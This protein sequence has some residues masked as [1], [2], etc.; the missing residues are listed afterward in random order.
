MKRLALL[1][2]AVVAFGPLTGHAQTSS[3]TTTATTTQGSANCGVLTQAA[4]NALNGRLEA[5]NSY[6]K[7]PE[8]VGTLSCLDSIFS[9][10]GLN[11]ISNITNPGAM[12]DSLL[13]NVEGQ[14]CSAAQSAWNGTVGA[15]QQCG[16]G[17]NGVNLGLGLDTGGGLMCPSLNFGGDGPQL[18]SVGVGNSTSN[19]YNNGVPQ[20]P[21]GYSD[22]TPSGGIF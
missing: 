18:G 11:L 14:I 20:L 3:A 22:T 2:G 16:L 12:I 10:T 13:N 8:A 21:T 19:F 6:E 4:A 5:N 7:Q 1:V 15:A 9:G 17:L